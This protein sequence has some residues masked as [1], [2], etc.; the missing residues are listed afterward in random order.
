MKTVLYVDDQEPTLYV[1]KSHIEL[2]GDFRVETSVSAFDALEMMRSRTY[3]AIISDYSMPGMNGIAFLKEVRTNYGD[4]PFIL[5]TSEVR[6]DILIGAV[7][8]GADFCIAKSGPS[9]FADLKQKISIAIDRKSARADLK[10]SLQSVLQH[11]YDMLDSHPDA[12]FIINQHKTV[13][14]WNR[15]MEAMTGVSRKAVLGTDLYSIPFFGKK[16]PLLVDL[17]LNRN[18]R[19]QKDITGP[20]AGIRWEGDKVS[21]E[22]FSRSVYHGSGGHLQVVVSPLNNAKG[23]T[24]GAIAAIRDITV[25]KKRE[26]ELT[27]TIEALHSSNAQLA[28]TAFDLQSFQNLCERESEEGKIQDH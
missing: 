21:A 15:G 28:S 8:N 26:E 24:I 27:R 3:D 9:P 22:I 4:I 18:L 1:V 14:L 16:R 13:L 6:D 2:F 11:I 17:V 19:Q 20:V 23:E 25:Y 10:E 7:N 5:F 12:T